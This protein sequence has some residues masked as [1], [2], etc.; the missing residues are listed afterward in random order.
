MTFQKTLAAGAV[1]LSLCLIANCSK[2]KSPTAPAAVTVSQTWTGKLID[3]VLSAA[4]SASGYT[5]ST[6]TYKLKSDGSY[7]LHMSFTPFALPL[8]GPRC[9]EGTWAERSDTLV[10][11]P[12]KDYVSNQST[13]AMDPADT[14]RAVHYGVK[15]SADSATVTPFYNVGNKT[16]SRPLGALILVKQ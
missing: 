8:P 13:G 12:I 4:F 9:E 2:E 15:S 6:Y 10:L 7:D 5:G 3:P 1:M 11:T 14:L 16:S